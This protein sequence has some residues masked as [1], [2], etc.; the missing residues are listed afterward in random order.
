MR[1]IVLLALCALL[2]ALVC[3]CEQQH[4]IQQAEAPNSTPPAHFNAPLWG[5]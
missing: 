2:S 5:R 1:V 3:G 4:M